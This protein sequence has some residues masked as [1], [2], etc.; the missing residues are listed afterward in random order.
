V[1]AFVTGAAQGLGR[2]ICVALAES[3]HD[4]IACD[5]DGED[6]SETVAEVEGAGRKVVAG[7]ADVRDQAQLDG[8]VADGVDAL[9]GLDVVVANAGISGWSRYWEMPEEQWQRM[10]DI[11][12]TG[13]WRTFK[14]TA[15]VL[16]EQG[17]GGSMIA[18][19]S[20]AGIKSLPGQ[21][22]YSA[23]KHGVVGLVKTAAIELGPFAI[24]VNS[25][26]PW[27]IN[28]RLA[29]ADHGVWEMIEANPTYAGS[30]GAI[31]DPPISE[32]HEVAAAVAWL[33]S[34]ASSSITGIQ[35]PVV[36]GAT[37]V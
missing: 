6:M 17:R 32:P 11:N 2:A 3:G 9:G 35:L 27:G 34:P 7:A 37:T 12:L 14:A 36:M 5:L 8:L 15:P 18:I 13:V 19:S 29:G 26:H 4:V 33:A 20:V 16:I 30:F 24:R 23:A 21:A 31:L 22:H 10:L 28:T 25:V 1:T